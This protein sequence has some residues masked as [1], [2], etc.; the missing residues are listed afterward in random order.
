MDGNDFAD[1]FGTAYTRF[2]GRFDSRNI[3]TNPR[4]IGPAELEELY[5]RV[6]G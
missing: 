4:P 1:F 5:R 3:T 2:N 6:M